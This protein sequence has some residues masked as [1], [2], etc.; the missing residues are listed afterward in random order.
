LEMNGQ[1]RYY[2]RGIV[3]D[4]G[5]QIKFA[6]SVAGSLIPLHNQVPTVTILGLNM[7]YPASLR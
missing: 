6:G 7:N 1:N 4:P 5:A 2:H 3:S